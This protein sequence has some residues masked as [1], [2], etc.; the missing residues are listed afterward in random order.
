MSQRLTVR[1]KG[2][3]PDPESLRKIEEFN[4]VLQANPLYAYVPHDKQMEF[5]ASTDKLKA[6]IG[7]NRSG[8][9][10]AAILDCLIQ[11][12]DKDFLPD[13]LKPYKHHEGEFYCRLVSPDFTSTMEGVIFHKIRQWVPRAALKGGSW[14]KAYDKQ[15]RV[16]RFANGSWW[17]F[18]TYEQDLD[19]FS[20][21]ALHRVCY[22]E[23]PPGDKG[24]AIRQECRARLVDFGGDEVF[25]F[26][27]LLGLSWA[28][29][30][31]WERR[32]DD[33]VTVVQV[34]MDDNPHLDQDAKRDF[35]AGLTKEEAE[36]RKSGKFVHF[37]GLFYPEYSDETHLR[38]A[39]NRDHLKGQDI[40]VGIDP[41]FRRTGVVWV[42][43]DNDNGAFVFDEFYPQE[44][45][46]GPISE[47]IKDRN[48]F[49]GVDP[50][51]VIDPSA[52]N[53]ATI[54]AEG[55]EAE[56]AREGIY[57]EHGQ[58]DRASGILEVKARLQQHRLVFS[59][60][61]RNILWEISRYRR[62]PRS[63]DEF[64]AIKRDDHLL[65][66]M[67]YAIMARAWGNLAPNV[68]RQRRRGFSPTY[69][70]P[71]SPP[72]RT[73]QQGPLGVFT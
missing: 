64:A 38:E 47:A 7:G 28:Y 53:R 49:W 12:V 70:P 37:S 59:S 23:E 68:G 27:P 32:H 30:A 66:A 43:F 71:W 13:N 15:R 3:K 50:I 2:G 1:V 48:E 40:V 54:N 4:Q 8:K 5:H 52:R 46:V 55:V 41:G 63:N 57:C 62:D 10:T 73:E 24:E 72:E 25:A 51:Y 16:L 65:D 21:A 35:L 18:L 14:D 61:C 17:D 36:A 22:D 67:R 9:T 69:E 11:S 26:T 34:D 39:P 56:F 20:G 33:D 45:V 31:I 60:D 42:A 19:K 29:D 58:N 44:M 6:F